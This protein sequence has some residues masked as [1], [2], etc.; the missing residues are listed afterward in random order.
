MAFTTSFNS[1]GIHANAFLA[2]EAA[3]EVKMAIEYP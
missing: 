2:G 3:I 1:S